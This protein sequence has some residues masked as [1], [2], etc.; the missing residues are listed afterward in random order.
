MQTNGVDLSA[1]IGGLKLKTVL[2]NASGAKDVTLAELET[3]GESKCSAIVLKSATLEARAGNAEPR[4]YSNDLGS[5]N[6]MGLPNLGFREYC[7]IVPLLK[8]FGKPIVASVAGFSAEEYL[9]MSKALEQA[10]ADAIELNLSCPNLAGKPQAGYDFEYCRQILHLV[11]PEVKIPLGCKLPPY[12]EIAHQ[13]EMAQILLDFKMDFVTLVN[14]VGNALVVDPSTQ[15]ATIKPKKGLGGLGGK[16]IKPVALGNVWSFYNLLAGKVA[17]KGCGGVYSGQDA[18]EHLLCGAQGVALGTV[19]YEQG[20]VAFARIENELAQVL[21]S[22][23]YKSAKEAVGK[24][25][26]I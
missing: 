3:I 16:Y 12:L 14:S 24:L 20:P 1:H 22:H 25:K 26:T 8:R 2:I 5:I 17:I 19:Y 10:G 23:G 18:F 13:Q 21:L 9:L 6:S 7:R 15:T 11:R 4:Y